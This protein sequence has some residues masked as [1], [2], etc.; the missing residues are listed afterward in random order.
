MSAADSD[1][2]LTSAPVTELFLTSE[3]ATAPALICTAVTLSRGSE[4]AANAV[5][6]SATNSA[7]IPMD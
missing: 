4:T 1:P 2:F 5:P 3:L 7:T 6:P